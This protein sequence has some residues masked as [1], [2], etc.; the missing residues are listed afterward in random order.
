MKTHRFASRFP[1]QQRGMALISVLAVLFLLTLLVV[2]FMA[3]TTGARASAANYRATASTAALADTAVNLVQAQINEA[4]T[5][6]L[7]NI[8]AA[9][10]TWGSQPGAIRVFDQT[11]SLNNIY[12]L[13]SATPTTA[14]SAR[15]ASGTGA[16]TALAA[17]LPGATADWTHKGAQWCDLNS[18]SLDSEGKYHFPIVDPRDT[19]ADPT[20][21]PTGVATLWQPASSVPPLAG[22]SI[23]APTAVGTTT[24]P[25]PMPVRWLYILKD[26][27]II[28]P[29]S[30]STASNQLTFL[31]A[32]D[33]TGAPDIPKVSNPIVGRI[34]YWT[35]DESSKIN[36]NT[37]AGDDVKR[38][39]NH[40]ASDSIFWAT[41]VF[42]APSE[43]FLASYQPDNGEIQRYSGHPGTV[44]LNTT[45]STLAGLTTPLADTDFFS[46]IPRYSYGGSKSATNATPSDGT[47]A[48]IVPLTANRL[49]TSIG[50]MIFK[51][52]R[53]QSALVTDTSETRANAAVERSNFFLTAHSSSSELNLFGEPRVS[54]WPWTTTYQTPIDQLLAFDSTVPR[55][56]GGGANPALFYFQRTDPTSTVTD[57][58]ISGNLALF[59]YLDT[60]TSSNI[61][62]FG[63]SFTHDKYANS[64]SPPAMRQII[65]EI[66][67]YV[68]TINMLDPVLLTQTPSAGVS[69]TYGQNWG[70][71]T[72]SVVAGGA[73]YQGTSGG[74]TTTYRSGSGGV[75]VVPS[76]N[77]G[78]GLIINTATTHTQGLGAFPIPVEIT[79]NFSALGLGSQAQITTPPPPYGPTAAAP[80]PSVQYAYPLL[81]HDDF[82]GTPSVSYDTF[83]DQGTA[84]VSGVPSTGTTAMQ[85]FVYVSFVN[86][87]Q[88]TSHIQPAFS[89]SMTGLN[90]MTVQGY[91]DNPTKTDGPPSAPGNGFY[92]KT[93]A[94]AQGGTPTSPKIRL[95]F[96]GNLANPTAPPSNALSDEEFMVVDNSD[97]AGFING[98]I[99]NWVFGY[100]PFFGETGDS[101]YGSS[102]ALLGPAPSGTTWSI[103]NPVIMADG[104]SSQDGGNRPRR[105]P[106]YSQIFALPGQS[107]WTKAHGNPNSTNCFNFNGSNGA[108]ITL[109]MYSAHQDTD[110]I[111]T[112]PKVATYSFIFPP[113]PVPVGSP[114]PQLPLPT[115]STA[116][117]QAIGTYNNNV[118]DGWTQTTDRW[119][120]QVDNTDQGRN[121][122]ART[123]SGNDVT[124]SL[125]LSPIW[126]DA[127]DLAMAQVTPT[128]ATV[129]GLNGAFTT[130]PLYGGSGTANGGFTAVNQAHS[131]LVQA[132]EPFIGNINP[133]N[134]GRLI[135]QT[136]GGANSYAPSTVSSPTALPSVSLNYPIVPPKL[137]GS[138]G[139]GGTS[140]Q[141]AYT[142]N[143]AGISTTGVPGDWDNGVAQQ[144]DGP[145]INMADEG[146]LVNQ[147]QGATNSVAYYSTG[148]LG[149]KTGIASTFSPSR[150]VQSPVTFGSL[151]TGINS[152]RPHPWQTLLFR[153]GAGAGGYGKYHWG[154]R[155]EP[156]SGDPADHLLLDLFWMPQA[157]PYPIS[158]P[159]VTEGKINLNYEIQ[160][161]TYITRDTAL[162]ALL[163]SEE[164]AVM[165][166]S[167]SSTYKGGSNDGINVTS[168]AISGKLGAYDSLGTTRL[169][170]DPDQTLGLNP[171]QALDP[172]APTYGTSSTTT[173]QTGVNAWYDYS[174]KT[175]RFFKSA[176]ELCEMFLVPKGL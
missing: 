35:D 96:P 132:N 154:E 32:V 168:T 113:S 98:Y 33:A 158:A 126:S 141:G 78:S 169:P 76:A 22:F 36:I 24:N 107:G 136:I 79:I 60:L 94:V 120:Y 71:P 74:N 48:P 28:S 127:R 72:S 42:S 173:A 99:G 20:A 41:P 47:A 124:Q 58:S 116:D 7:S 162:R 102:P 147:N 170:I 68:R 166:D 165:P 57:C 10:Y 91:V 83:T 137:N 37:A 164:I 163:A 49:Y 1:R 86:P 3:R 45:L 12:R 73:G 149:Q 25:A 89:Y 55:S 128:N 114:T 90:N 97:G 140:G 129:G 65:A 101:N 53:T 109:T 108:A 85:A 110:V 93:F 104:K 29:D 171:N 145:W 156:S 142:Y 118:A 70:S 56:A 87:G 122:F 51:A 81:A 43:V 111:A 123:I 143:G 148:N 157:E 167:L 61:P 92:D 88:I 23:N 106:F 176:S 134:W 100:I 135:T 15:V 6:G 119:H 8:G 39:S 18:F 95:F 67:D 160:P 82:S 155:N 50:E 2:A 40:Y 121:F 133:T 4:T 11:G 150:M 103:A 125:V 84:P 117:S 38:G 152:T 75:Q 62:G 27:A 31:N 175:T 5:L 151:P 21:V 59:T 131:L 54:I 46:L 146:G 63:T 112:T 138:S 13:Y 159:F 26:G 14:S 44:G 80:V 30:P 66:F 52:D 77:N 69:H 9:T 139:A 105:F 19:G 115:Y 17:D 161:F 130:H 64:T 174:A 34:A 144:A 172:H 153:P 16:V